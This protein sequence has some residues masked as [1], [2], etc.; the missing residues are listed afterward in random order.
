MVVI[1]AEKWLAET[2]GFKDPRTGEVHIGIGY[3]LLLHKIIGRGSL[4]WLVPKLVSIGFDEIGAS[5]F[6]HLMEE[7]LENVLSSVPRRLHNLLYRVVASM[8][9]LSR[10]IENVKDVALLD[11][12]HRVQ[13]KSKLG[14]HKGVAQLLEE[15]LEGSREDLEG[16]AYGLSRL[17]SMALVEGSIDPLDYSAVILHLASKNRVV[18][19]ILARGL[20]EFFDSNHILASE[21][22][23][24]VLA[25]NTFKHGEFPDYAARRLKLLTYSPDIIVA[26][27]AQQ[28]QRKQLDAE[29]IDREY[30]KPCLVLAIHHSEPGLYVVL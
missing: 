13:Y 27:R 23:Y 17:T 29:I 9:I 18:S 8:T 1:K 2:I 16:V 30:P 11:W 7:H 22:S 10:G 21:L 3:D 4:E 25:I 14:S 19:G 24:H 26:C 6:K 28:L 5:I 20:L 12:L 15:L